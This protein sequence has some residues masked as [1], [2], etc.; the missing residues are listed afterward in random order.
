[1]SDSRYMLLAFMLGCVCVCVFSE[2]DLLHSG[3]T[4]PWQISSMAPSI[5]SPVTEHA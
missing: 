1:M 2:A 5:G 4:W 3:G